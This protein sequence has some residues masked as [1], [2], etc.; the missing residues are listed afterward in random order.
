[1][2]E[3]AVSPPKKEISEGLVRNEFRTLQLTA[4]R[5]GPNSQAMHFKLVL[6]YVRL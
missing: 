5:S 6:L 4:G 2:G 1:M 3:T